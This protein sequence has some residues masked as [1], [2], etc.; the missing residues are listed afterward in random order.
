MHVGESDG[1]ACD[2]TVRAEG[3]TEST[4]SGGDDVVGRVDADIVAGVNLV[5]HIDSRCVKGTEGFSVRCTEIVDENI[6][7]SI[8]GSAKSTIVGSAIGVKLVFALREPF[9]V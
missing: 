4:R 2:D 3:H 6:G 5:G 7:L 8:P 1:P 9:G